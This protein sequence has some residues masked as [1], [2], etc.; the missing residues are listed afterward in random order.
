MESLVLCADTDCGRKS[1][2]RHFGLNVTAWVYLD[3]PPLHV[4]VQ[5][6][7]ASNPPQKLRNFF[8]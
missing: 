1:F 2:A 3:G 6:Y 8:F 7:K 5:L 4:S